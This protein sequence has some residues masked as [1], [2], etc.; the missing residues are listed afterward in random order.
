MVFYEERSQTAEYKTR[1]TV[2]AR[3]DVSEQCSAALEHT[4]PPAILY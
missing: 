1:S 3:V 4:V 2:L